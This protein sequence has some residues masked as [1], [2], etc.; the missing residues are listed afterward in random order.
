MSIEI[1]QSNPCRPCLNKIR[2]LTRIVYGASQEGDQSA[3]I[4]SEIQELKKVQKRC[5]RNEDCDRDVNLGRK[6]TRP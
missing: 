5:K 6:I 4:K 2:D 1:E 3:L